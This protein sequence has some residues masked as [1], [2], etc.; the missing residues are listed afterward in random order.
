MS[1]VVS[2]TTYSSN[3]WKNTIKSI[4]KLDIFQQRCLRNIMNIKW[5]DRV[6]NSEVL[7]RAGMTPLRT[8]IADRRIQLM[9]HAV[10]SPNTTPAREVLEW[11]PDGRTA[12]ER[13]AFNYKRIHS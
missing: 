3:T 4:Q 11:I 12:K 1:I 10:R 9:C 2:T 13:L 6:T 8:L 5:Q 7:Y